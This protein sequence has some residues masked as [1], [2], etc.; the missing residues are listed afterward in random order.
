M[1][2][3]KGTVGRYV[4]APIAN[5]HLFNGRCE[6]PRDQ[7]TQL[8]AT[9]V[10]TE[11]RFISLPPVEDTIWQYGD[12]ATSDGIREDNRQQRAP[13]ILRG[14]H[15]NRLR[16]VSDEGACGVSST[17]G[18]AVAV[19]VLATDAQGGVTD[20]NGNRQ[21]N[22]TA[23]IPP[24]QQ[25]GNGT[26]R[27]T[28]FTNAAGTEQTQYDPAVVNPTQATFIG[29]RKFITD[30]YMGSTAQN[31][32]GP[33]NGCAIY[34]DLC[35]NGIGFVPGNTGPIAGTQAEPDTGPRVLRAHFLGLQAM[36]A[37]NDKRLYVEDKGYKAAQP[38][39]WG[40]NN[41]VGDYHKHVIDQETVNMHEFVGAPSVSPNDLVRKTDIGQYLTAADDVGVVVDVWHENFSLQMINSGNGVITVAYGQ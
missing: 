29:A 6:E 10:A 33:K 2:L 30:G 32:F 38:A 9:N 31:H 18:I 27:T 13:T 1:A 11:T 8:L 16:F 23:V 37:H 7:G 41:L 35:L 36:I 4:E 21:G 24:G 12:L 39:V 3:D 19:P 15:P 34:Q 25:G 20:G 14:G 22:V 17:G 40:A 28:K 5:T 26:L